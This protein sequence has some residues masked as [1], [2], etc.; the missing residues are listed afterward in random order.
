[1]ISLASITLALSVTTALQ[2]SHFDYHVV[3]QNGTETVTGA[4]IS[5]PWNVQDWDG[6][7]MPHLSI[8]QPAD[9]TQSFEPASV[10]KTCTSDGQTPA[11]VSCEIPSETASGVGTLEPRTYYLRMISNS[12]LTA[13]RDVGMDITVSGKAGADSVSKKLTGIM[14]KVDPNADMEIIN[15]KFPGM[16]NFNDK[17]GKSTT[18]LA[19]AFVSDLAHGVREPESRF[20]VKFVE[21]KAF[22]VMDLYI[23]GP[24]VTGTDVKN[25]V[26]D[27]GVPIHQQD[28]E[29]ANTV[30]RRAVDQMKYSSSRM[31][32]ITTS[33]FVQFYTDGQTQHLCTD[34][35]DE[36]KF[37]V[38][39][40]VPVVE[41]D[42]SKIVFGIAVAAGVIFGLIF[43]GAFLHK[44][45][46]DAKAK[47]A[48]KK[49]AEAAPM[50]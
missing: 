42:N 45:I 38:D 40:N 25:E 9:P 11:T 5:F 27:N 47:D 41:S 20:F 43:L 48:A 31:R 14:H 28:V 21:S 50:V 22:P 46:R 32:Q 49:S 34:G 2:G 1:M 8:Y 29:S 12:A 30:Y 6:A 37:R 4:T 26:D 3:V 35:A 44:K 15:V 39:C 33:N 24:H 17:D 18:A 19:Q 23:L 10:S 7:K 36:G 16:L 13:A